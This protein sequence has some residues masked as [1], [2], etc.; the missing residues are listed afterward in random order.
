M[1][2]VRKIRNG[3]VKINGIVYSPDEAY[4]GEL[5]GMWY[6]FGL[7]EHPSPRDGKMFISLWG[8]KEQYFS[9]EVAD[10]TFGKTPDCID[11]TFHWSWWSEVC[12]TQRAVDWATV[13]PI[14]RDWSSEE[15][16]KAWAYLQKP[17]RN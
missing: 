3:T 10:K 2:A 6:A 1:F 16:D 11:G 14:E 4:H 17:P 15:E 5:D 9:E 7:Y 12:P 13:S 8:T